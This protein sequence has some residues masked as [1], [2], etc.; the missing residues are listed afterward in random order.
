MF[1]TDRRVAAPARDAAAQA[2]EQFAT[3]R[4]I[5]EAAASEAAAAALH[6]DEDARLAHMLMQDEQEQE[7]LAAEVQANRLREEQERQEQVRRR[8][9]HALFRNKWDEMS[10]FA[11]FVEVFSELICAAQEFLRDVHG[12]ER[13]VVSLRDVARC[14]K[15]LIYL[16]LYLSL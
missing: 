11:E 2:A 7:R 8:D 4:A 5:A 12:Q 16:S 13:S 9:L 15:V 14:V 6:M 3:Q 1:A 10:P